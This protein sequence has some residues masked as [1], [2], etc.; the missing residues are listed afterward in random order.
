MLRLREPAESDWIDIG[1]VADISVSH[2]RSAPRQTDW[3]QKRLAFQGC[4]RHY[5]IEHDGIVVGYGSLEKR[6]ADPTEECRMF[7]ALSWNDS[8]NIDVADGLLSRLREDMRRLDI[9]HVW[10]REYA[11]DHP[12][13]DF[14]LARGFEITKEYEYEGQKLI[15]LRST[16]L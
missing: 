15:N 10:L 6:R 3:L 13:I 5:V 4:R 14:L 16:A 11:E 1:K 7:L 12:F 2:V 8:S 9:A